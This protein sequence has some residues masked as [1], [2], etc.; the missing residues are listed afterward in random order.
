MKIIIRTCLLLSLI[1]C[2]GRLLAQNTERQQLLD[3]AA[4]EYLRI[5]G[6]QSM[7]YYGTPQV[8]HPR[9]T[10]HPYLVNMQFVKSRLSYN[11]IIYPEVLLR[12]D[13]SRD[14]LVVQSPGFRN[15]VLFPENVDFVELHGRHI[16]YFYR[17]SLPNSPSTGYYT[18]LYSGNCTVMQ[19]QTANITVNRDTLE[20]YYNLITIFYL[21][22][23]GVYYTIRN[24]RELLKALQPYKKELKQFISNNN[25]RFRHNAE[26]LIT[27]TVI[28]YE[29]LSGVRLQTKVYC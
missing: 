25:L 2:C 15:V 18:L 12:F 27:Q 21:Y 7:L 14:E 29:K 5:A 16:I 23:D 22:N 20:E 24:K 19:K 17:D 1:L 8:G 3:N 28:E 10:N 11:R 6:N 13:L 4:I 26:G 9:T